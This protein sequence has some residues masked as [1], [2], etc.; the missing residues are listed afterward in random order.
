MTRWQIPEPLDVEFRPRPLSSANV[1][2]GRMSDGRF[3]IRIAH[4]LIEGVTPAMLRWWISM[5]DQQVEWK[6]RTVLAYRL[7]H[8][9]DHIHFEITGRKADGSVEP[10]AT[11]HLVEAFGAQRRFLIEQRFELSK[12]DETGFV[13]TG[14]FHGQRLE[15]KE[16]FEA[17]PGGTKMVVQARLGK[18]NAL[19]TRALSR[20]ILLFEPAQFEAWKR[21]NVEEDG[22]LSGFLPALYARYRGGYTL[23][24]AGKVL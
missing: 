5:L 17:A 13:L 3:Q 6:G 14:A 12:L 9:R 8:P 22:T 1:T 15:L 24:P 20:L 21:H 19:F 2:A 16:S 18:P 4:A 23:G 7:W 11:Y 10:P